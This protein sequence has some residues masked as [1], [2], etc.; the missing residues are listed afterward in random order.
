MSRAALSADPIV[1]LAGAYFM[2]AFAKCE[3]IFRFSSRLV[4]LQF[5]SKSRSQTINDG[6]GRIA[7]CFPSSKLGPL[8]FGAGCGL[9]LAPGP[10]GS[11]NGCDPENM[12]H[13]I[14]SVRSGAGVTV[15]V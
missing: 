2:F 13:G 8:H 11:V 9:R 14:Q 7:R 10:R 4:N 5:S 12:A 3:D 1:K 15:S 6:S